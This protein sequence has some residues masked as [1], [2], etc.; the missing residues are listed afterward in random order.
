MKLKFWGTRGSCAAPFADRREFGGNTS[1]VMLRSGNTWL[2]CDAGTGVIPLAAEIREAA[3]APDA[4]RC[5]V[6]ILISHFHLDHIIGLPMFLAALPKTAEVTLYAVPCAKQLV[7]LIGP[8]LWPVRLTDVCPQLQF[9]DLAQ[10]AEND[11]GAGIM[12]QTMPSNHP[13]DTTLYRIRWE[14]IDVVYGLDCEITD[15]FEATYVR[16]ARD[17]D[18]LLYD[19]AYTDE[20]YTRCVGFGHSPCSRATTIADQ[21]GAKRVCVLHYDYAYTDDQLRRTEATV[22]NGDT[23]IL[24]AREGQ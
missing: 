13:N 19:G 20:D 3:T 14:G 22:T 1:C 10:S 24:F 9:A 11:L 12:V 15:A 21:T 7:T 18:C 4:E 2:V 23:R 8:P 6:K 5:H 17:C 16:F